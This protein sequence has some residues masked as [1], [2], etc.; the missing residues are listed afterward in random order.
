M[1]IK[2][3]NKK[4]LRYES[5]SCKKHKDCIASTGKKSIGDTTIIYFD[6]KANSPHDILCVGN[7]RYKIV[8]GLKVTVPYG[9]THSILSTDPKSKRTFIAQDKEGNDVMMSSLW[10]KIKKPYISHTFSFI[11]GAII[12]LSR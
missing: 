7:K 6:S 9:K 1:E 11:V 5:G 4:S 3:Y 10:E 8:P 12:A 2:N